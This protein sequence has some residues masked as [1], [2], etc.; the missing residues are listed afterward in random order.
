MIERR[1]V[2]VGTLSLATIARSAEAQPRRARVAM[3]SPALSSVLLWRRVGLPELARAGWSEGENLEFLPF[4]PGHD[5][6]D[7]SELARRL[8][9]TRPDVAIAVSNPAALA[10]RVSAPD[11]PIVMAF[12]GNDPVADGLARS[13]ARPGGM[14]TGIVMLA[15]ELN[16]KRVELARDTFP[17]RPIGFLFGSN[18][19]AARMDVIARGARELGATLVLSGGADT[20]IAA[21][22]DEFRRAAVGSVVVGSSPVLSGGARDIAALAL[23]ANLPTFVEWRRMVEAGCAMSYGPNEDDI[24]RRSARYVVRVL[25]GARPAEMPMEQP[26]RFE[27]IVNQRTISAIGANLPTHILARADEVIE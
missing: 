8:A 4:V 19:L 10:I 2:L 25:R 7:L 27:L 23:A 24:R 13:L 17:G 18:T 6:L 22:F 5:T 12:A 14:V 11:L 20:S 3:L 16:L 9:D 21:S 15:D 26:D 1:T